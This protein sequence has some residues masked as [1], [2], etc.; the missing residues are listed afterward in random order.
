LSHMG[1]YKILDGVSGDS[2]PGEGKKKGGP[3]AGEG[4]RNLKSYGRWKSLCAEVWI[5]WEDGFT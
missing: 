4:E 2:G 3:M 1:G 5:N